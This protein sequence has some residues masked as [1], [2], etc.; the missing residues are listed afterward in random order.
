MAK[1]NRLSYEPPRARDLTGLSVSGQEP[2]G[3]CTTG[4]YP[5]A[6]CNQGTDDGTVP[7]PCN[8]QG[9]IPDTGLQC[10]PFG[11]TADSVCSG[12]GFQ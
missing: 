8:P 2:L 9:S 1:S 6:S 7:F 10:R 5:Y 4:W 11:T 3:T 12:G